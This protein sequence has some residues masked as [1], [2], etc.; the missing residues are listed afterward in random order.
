M[1]NIT[2]RTPLAGVK[3]FES[4][5][6]PADS[7]DLYWRD[8]TPIIFHISDNPDRGQMYQNF[9]ARIQSCIK[10]ENLQY[11]EHQDHSIITAEF[12]CFKGRFWATV[13]HDVVTLH[14]IKPILPE[15]YEEKPEELSKLHVEVFCV[16][17]E[18]ALL[19]TSFSPVDLVWLLGFWGN[20]FG[21]YADEIWTAACRRHPL[22]TS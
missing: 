10:P 8:D 21:F 5:T 17:V 12:R 16:N 18:E 2:N 11:F 6:Y 9:L 20:Q 14:R 22:V 15:E 7:I 4:S 3:L 13:D 19:A 1:L